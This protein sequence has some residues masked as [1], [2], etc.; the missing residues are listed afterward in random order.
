MTPAH[1]RFCNSG[2]DGFLIGDVDGKSAGIGAE[3]F[4][5]LRDEILIEIE[6]GDFTPLVD[7]HFRGCPA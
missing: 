7:Y 2:L 3:L 5:R 4:C 1:H 6:E